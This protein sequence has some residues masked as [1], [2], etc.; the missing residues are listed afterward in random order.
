MTINLINVASY[1]LNEEKVST[2]PLAVFCKLTGYKGDATHEKH[3]TARLF[4]TQEDFIKLSS[5]ELTEFDSTKDVHV[6]NNGQFLIFLKDGATNT[7]E[8]S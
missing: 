7:E 4:K 5:E 8:N 3:P 1:D 6:L 2:I